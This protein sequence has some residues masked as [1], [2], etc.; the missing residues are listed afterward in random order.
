MPDTRDQ[1]L[2]A[3]SMMTTEG[4]PMNDALPEDTVATLNAIAAVP[5]RCFIIT[6]A[7]MV[8][9]WLVWHVLGDVIHSVHHQLYGL[10][11]KEFNLY[12]LYSMTVMKG[13][14]V[15]FFLFP[16]AAITWYLREQR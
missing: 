5:F 2:I 11:P 6:L 15:I 9:T 12:F 3:R 8:F 1:I 10:S 4:K 13:L 7:A 16:F 14:I